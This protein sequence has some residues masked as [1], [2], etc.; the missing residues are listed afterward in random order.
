MRLEAFFG[1]RAAGWALK[2]A[3]KVQCSFPVAECDK[4]LDSPGA[5]L[6]GMGTFAR[7]MFFKANSRIFRKT[8]VITVGI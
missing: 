2:V 1:E 8:S 3:L 6:L 5:M 7:I 4:V